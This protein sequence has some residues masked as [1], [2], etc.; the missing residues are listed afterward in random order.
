[1]FSSF[2]PSTYISTNLVHGCQPVYV[3]DDFFDSLSSNTT[4]GSHR[5]RSIFSEEKKL[6]TEVQLQ[7]TL[8][9]IIPIP[10]IDLS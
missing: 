8:T 10:W 6:N 2:F 5:G 7:L 4:G 3:K 9:I 1:M